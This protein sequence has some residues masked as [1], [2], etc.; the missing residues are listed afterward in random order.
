MIFFSERALYIF[1]SKKVEE[2]FR[3]FDEQGSG[4][5]EEEEFK[6]AVKMLEF[7]FSPAKFSKFWNQIDSDD[8]GTIKLDEFRKVIDMMNVDV[9]ESA[10]QKHKVYITLE[11]FVICL[12]LNV[13][14]FKFVKALLY[15]CESCHSGS[16][17]FRPQYATFLSL[18]RKSGVG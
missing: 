7:D 4:Q 3:Y 9:T 2:T 18:S 10:G 14:V 15:D 13:V 6:Q 16:G 5:L 11:A 1:T 17:R 12:V 8:G